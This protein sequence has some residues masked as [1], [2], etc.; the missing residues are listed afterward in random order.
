MAEQGQS[1]YLISQ[2]ACSR[3][4]SVVSSTTGTMAHGHLQR[5][6]L[7]T[8]VRELSQ[9]CQPSSVPGPTFAG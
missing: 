7:Q 2:P 1:A 6:V 4:V 5:R 3:A 9:P 8:Q